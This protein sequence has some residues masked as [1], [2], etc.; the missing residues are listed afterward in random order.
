MVQFTFE[1]VGNILGKGENVVSSEASKVII[2]WSMTR[3]QIKS[4]NDH[5]KVVF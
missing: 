5:Q 2:V 4:F 1:R 3:Q